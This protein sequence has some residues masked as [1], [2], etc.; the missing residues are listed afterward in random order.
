MVDGHGWW[1]KT[2]NG[3][4]YTMKLVRDMMHHHRC[5]DTHTDLIFNPL[6]LRCSKVYGNTINGKTYNAVIPAGPKCYLYFYVGGK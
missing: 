1:D 2:G 6:S 3:A 5:L 4:F